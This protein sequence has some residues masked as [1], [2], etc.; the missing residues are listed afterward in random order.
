MIIRKNY[1]VKLNKGD[2]YYNILF[3]MKDLKNSLHFMK[4]NIPQVDLEPIYLIFGRKHKNNYI[5]IVLP[6][7]TINNYFY[8]YQSEH[9]YRDTLTNAIKENAKT[10]LTKNGYFY[11]GDNTTLNILNDIEIENTIKKRYIINND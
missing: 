4:Y 11:L 6:L 1:D 10:E 2:M 5:V 8:V 7:E 9:M 3:E